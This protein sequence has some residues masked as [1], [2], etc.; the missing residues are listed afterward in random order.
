MKKITFNDFSID[1][2]LYG[3]EYKKAFSET[4][5]SGYFILGDNVKKFEKEFAKYL[6]STYCIGVANGLEAIQI[7]LL[8]LGIGK[9]DEVITT[10]I[11]AVATTLAILGVGAKPVFVDTTEDGLL[12]PN[13]IL[14]AITKK[15]KAILPV[16]LYGHSSYIEELKKI[17]KKYRIY[18]VEDACQAHGSTY[19]KQKLGTFGDI[20]CFSFYPTKNLGCFGDGGAIV[21]NNPDLAKLCFEIRDYG[22]E[23]KYKHTRLGMNSRLDEIQAAFLRVKLRYLDTNNRKRVVVAKRYIKNLSSLKL[24]VIRST[25][26]FGSN[27]HLFVIKTQERDALKEFLSKKNIPTGI[28]YPLIIPDQPFFTQ[29]VPYLPIARKFINEILSLPCHPHMSFEQVDFISEKI[30]EFFKTQSRNLTTIRTY[31]TLPQN[32][33][34]TV[35][36][37]KKE[38]YQAINVPYTASALKNHKEKYCSEKDRFEYVLAFQNG[39][40]SGGLTLLKREVMYKGNILRLGGIAGLWVKTYKQKNGIGSMLVNKALDILKKNNCDIAY[41]QIDR[42]SLRRFYQKFNF[43]LLK[44]EHS[45]TGRSGKKYYEINGMIAPLSTDK[46]FKE[47]KKDSQSFY[48]GKGNW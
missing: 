10:P 48:I 31:K 40:I 43:T 15:T 6:G 46:F 16:H 5:T 26:Y 22:Q 13:L 42:I 38:A 18:L 44:K 35:K 41:L 34:G 33:K 8:A 29:K 7:S 19:L 24:D 20:G 30:R 4:L 9:G 2:Q 39:K 45:F 14:K 37:L 11:S 32:L 23:S 3:S 47:I 21:T 17:C 1:A 36:K 25:D 28:H 12:D 27:F